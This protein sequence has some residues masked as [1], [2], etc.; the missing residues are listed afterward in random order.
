VPLGDGNINPGDLSRCALVHIRVK[1][2]EGS[3]AA[4]LAHPARFDP[5]A[6]VGARLSTGEKLDTFAVERNESQDHLETLGAQLPSRRLGEH[7][8][9]SKSGHNNRP[10]R[11]VKLLMAQVDK[12]VVRSPEK[13]GV[14]GST[15]SL[16]TTFGAGREWRPLFP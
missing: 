1:E 3:S 12:L 15:P 13:A 14:G 11:S 4:S 16:A 6:W 2:T 8:R 10:L 9:W 5:N 7:R